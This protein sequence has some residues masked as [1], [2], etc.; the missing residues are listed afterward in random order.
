MRTLRRA[1]RLPTNPVTHPLGAFTHGGRTRLLASSPGSAIDPSLSHLYP[2]LHHTRRRTSP[3]QVVF[4]PLSPSS[5]ACLHVL[6]IC[7]MESFDVRRVL[8]ADRC[9]RTLPVTP[10]PPGP[11]C[12]AAYPTLWHAHEPRTS[13]AT[14]GNVSTAQLMAGSTFERGESRREENRMETVENE[15][16]GRQPRWHAPHSWPSFSTTTRA[17]VSLL[18]VVICQ[19]LRSGHGKSGARMRRISFR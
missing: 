16:K 18:V 13:N 12:L 2:L 8:E 9:E 3:I 4:T 6:P 19:R 7:G 15:E 5:V 17:H 11:A 14:A 1:S 10:S